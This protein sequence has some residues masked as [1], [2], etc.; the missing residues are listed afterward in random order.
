[1]EA[2]PRLAAERRAGLSLMQLFLCPFPVHRPPAGVQGDTAAIHP[3]RAEGAEGPQGC[4]DTG[5]Q[6]P[7]EAASVPGSGQG[8]LRRN[9]SILT[10]HTRPGADAARGG[11]FVMGGCLVS[12]THFLQA[13]AK[14]LPPPTSSSSDGGRGHVDGRSCRSRMRLP[15]PFAR[16]GTS[17][18]PE[19]P[20]PLG[21]ACTGALFGTPRETSAARMACCPSPFRTCWLCSVSTGHP[22]RG[23]AG[24]QPTSVPPTRSERPSIAG[25]RSTSK[26]SL[27]CCCW[28]SS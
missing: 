15:W 21:S 13:C 28:L 18:A 3:V 20:G 25:W 23:S 19:A 14:Q 2:L 17:V 10:S 16:P 6:Q 24:R 7:G 27:C 11:P 1:M 4:N 5:C 12:A 8:H 26:A 22:R 9:L